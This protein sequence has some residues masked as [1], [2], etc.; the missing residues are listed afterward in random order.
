MILISTWYGAFLVKI[1]QDGTGLRLHS[2]K[3]F[4]GAA[5]E[6]VRKHL[7]K[8]QGQILEE[9]RT[10]AAGSRDEG[11]EECRK[12]EGEQEQNEG[13]EKGSKGREGARAPLFC[14][15]ERL[16]L[17]PDVELMEDPGK[18]KIL[19]TLFAEQY[20]PEH[21]NFS[22]GSYKEVLSVLARRKTEKEK[23]L[24]SKKLILLLSTR[25]ELMKSTNFVKDQ[26]YDYLAYQLERPLTR[27][28]YRFDVGELV[29][30]TGGG[31]GSEKF[32]ELRET[33]TSDDEL[34]R[35]C[36]LIS[37]LSGTQAE[38][39]AKIEES[40]K[41]IMPNTSFLT[42]PLISARLLSM[43]GG[44]KR[45]ALLPASTIQTLGAEKSLFKHLKDNTPPPKHGIIFQYPELRRVPRKERGK[46]AR[47]LATKIAIAARLDYF[48]GDFRGGELKEKLEKR[49]NAI[50]EKDK[51]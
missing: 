33:I 20:P 9:E 14:L 28:E 30:D 50:R 35:T 5:N 4:P 11:G 13:P 15:E 23:D 36:K 51:K 10:L 24:D 41:N 19:R 8:E 31:S 40:T 44:L 26:M 16:A 18:Q 45:L 47:L 25:D 7:M 1:A 37:T 2:G 29:N 22:S 6:L 34:L 43:V 39:D 46:V 27:K 38:L 32:R 42:G 3:L 48:S 49:I 17:L 21:F 12:E